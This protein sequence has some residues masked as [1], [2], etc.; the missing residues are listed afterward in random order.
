MGG[1]GV[2]FLVALGKGFQRVRAGRIDLHREWM[3]RAFAIALGIV[4]MRLIFVSVAGGR[5]G[6]TRERAEVISWRS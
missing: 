4:T 6:L 3:I 1:F 2:G 5:S